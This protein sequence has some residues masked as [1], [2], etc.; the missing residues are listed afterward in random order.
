MSRLVSIGAGLMLAVYATSAWSLPECKPP[1]GLDSAEHDNYCMIHAVRVACLVRKG[2]DLEGENWSV[3]LSA[4]DECTIRGCDQLLEQ[5]GA[6]SEALFKSACD[7][8]KFDR[9]G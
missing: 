7:V 1:V 9:S 6:L 8:V 4:Y 3:P 5:T 2:Y